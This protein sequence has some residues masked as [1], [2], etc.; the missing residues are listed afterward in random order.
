M[1]IT[2]TFDNGPDPQT[3][4][5]V[6]DVLKKHNIR[7]AFFVLGNRI[8][9]DGAKLA[10]RAVAEGHLLGNHTYTHSSPLGQRSD[11]EGIDEVLK[12]EE[13]LQNLVRGERLFRPH[14]GR[15]MI[16]AHLLSKG[17]WDL[18]SQHKYTCVLWNCMAYEWESPEDW[19]LPTL[20]R[21]REREHSV[22]VLHDLPS[23]AMQ[24]LDEFIE[25]LKAEEATFVQSFPD[26]CTPMRSGRVIWPPDQVENILQQRILSF[27]ADTVLN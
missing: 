1:K 6:L 25:M 9:G 20:E 12:T 16:G 7:A 19:M 14:G 8:I 22:V 23:G 2:L 26:D 17:V 11:A 13:A 10:A 21:T 4:P 3:T 15:G 18:L 24:R 5:Y 27:S